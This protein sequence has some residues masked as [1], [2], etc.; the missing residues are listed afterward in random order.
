MTNGL[1][2]AGA[3]LDQGM[4]VLRAALR[5]VSWGLP[6]GTTT[7]GPVGSLARLDSS[8]AQG[9]VSFTFWGL[10]SRGRTL[11]PQV[12]DVACYPAPMELR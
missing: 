12:V 10:P 11:Q 5:S 3:V 6:S 9:P 8:A 4:Q 2:L 7:P 1:H